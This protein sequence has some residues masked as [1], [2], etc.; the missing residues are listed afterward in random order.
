MVSKSGLPIP[1]G[2]VA[3][4]GAVKSAG[5][6]VLSLEVPVW[7]EKP[8]CPLVLRHPGFESFTVSGEP[9]KAGGRLLGSLRAPA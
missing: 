9:G 3:S 8:E 1:E 5:R 2:L 7:E 4:G 6:A